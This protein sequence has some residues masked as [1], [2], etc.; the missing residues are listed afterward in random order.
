MAAAMRAK[1]VTIWKEFMVLLFN[2]SN[3]IGDDGGPC[4]CLA[5]P[6]EYVS[7]ILVRILRRM[8]EDLPKIGCQVPGLRNSFLSVARAND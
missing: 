6:G 1:R 7:K 8:V 4:W 2:L 5:T 3:V